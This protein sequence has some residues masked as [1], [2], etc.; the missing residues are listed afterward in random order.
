MSK[1]PQLHARRLEVI[2][3][4]FTH[5][6]LAMTSPCLTIPAIIPWYCRVFLL[7]VRL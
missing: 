2:C 5:L 3:V 6:H 1:L 7:I 4:F